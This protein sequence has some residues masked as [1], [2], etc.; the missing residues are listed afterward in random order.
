MNIMI[1]GFFYQLARSGIARVWNDLIEEW[2][3]V[4][5]DIKFYFMDRE[6]QNIKLNCQIIPTPKVPIEECFHTWSLEPANRDRKLI[7]KLCRELD[8]DIFMSTYYTYSDVAINL[9]YIHDCIPERFPNLINLDEPIWKMKSDAIYHSS[10]YICVSENTKNDLYSFYNVTD[11]PS[12]IALNGLSSSFLQTLGVNKLPNVVNKPFI[13]VPGLSNKG[14]YKNHDLIF[15]AITPML[16]NGDIQCVCTGGGASELIGQYF[17]TVDSTKI[18][19]GYFSEEELISLY[20]KALAVVY[21]SRYEGFGLPIIEGFSRGTPV[22]TCDNSS[23]G[24]VGKKLAIYVNEDNPIELREKINLLLKT[25]VS[26]TFDLLSRAEISRF[27]WPDSVAQI[28]AF[29]RQIYLEGKHT[30]WMS[31]NG[32]R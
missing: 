20:D 32:F 21:T 29:V 22:I 15:E 4:S 5:P 28:D 13:L 1:D 25:P 14:S 24:E 7:N 16:E 17:D 30:K 8:I 10:G 18:V 9:L 31:E 19:T 6:Q 2:S 23:L 26:I 12:V 27:V 11:R 3:S